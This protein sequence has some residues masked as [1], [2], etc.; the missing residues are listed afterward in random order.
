MSGEER[1]E[2]WEAASETLK[3][4]NQALELQGRRL[5]DLAA[6]H[7]SHLKQ[8]EETLEQTRELMKM[9]RDASAAADQARAELVTATAALVKIASVM[10]AAITALTDENE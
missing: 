4:T 6:L 10:Q 1:G 9:A 2:S 7:E 3:Q 5:D 8:W